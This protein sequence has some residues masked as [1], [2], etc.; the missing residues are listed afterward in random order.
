MNY[1]KFTNHE[2]YLVFT[3]SYDGC[4][5]MKRGGGA[6][7]SRP[8]VTT[9]TAATRVSPG[10]GRKSR[11]AQSQ[12][13]WQ[14]AKLLWTRA[15]PRPRR[16]TA[17]RLRPLRGPKSPQPRGTRRAIPSSWAAENSNFHRPRPLPPDFRMTLRVTFKKAVCG[18]R[19]IITTITNYKWYDND[20]SYYIVN[21]AQTSPLI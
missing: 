17:F 2:F 15:L 18:E 16:P 13:P 20:L 10:L 14:P 3:K 9:A 19:K 7:A 21:S 12:P 5:C 8:T 4:G 1:I 6:P 11:P